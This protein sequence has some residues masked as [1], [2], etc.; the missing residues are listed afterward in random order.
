MYCE[1]ERAELYKRRGIVVRQWIAVG[2][3]G[4]FWGETIALA[5][6]TGPIC[7]ESTMVSGEINTS[8]LANAN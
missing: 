6:R 4:I 2:S 8:G 5:S 1:R 7:R 3:R